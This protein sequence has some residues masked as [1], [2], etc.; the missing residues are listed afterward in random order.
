[1]K[2]SIFLTLLLLSLYSYASR[3]ISLHSHKL[4]MEGVLPAP[5]HTLILNIELDEDTDNVLKFQLIRG[6]EDIEIPKEIISKLQGVDLG[7]VKVSHEMHRLDENRPAHSQ[8]GEEGDWL[9]INFD[10]GKYYKAIKKIKGR[11]HYKWGKD[12]AEI[13]IIKNRT[14][15]L[16]ITTLTESDY[17]WAPVSM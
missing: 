15:T 11:E 10:L 14:V 5:Y 1:M 13:T 4:Y 9:H 17:Y 6:S 12:H 8:W 2:V 16:K 7:T 3:P